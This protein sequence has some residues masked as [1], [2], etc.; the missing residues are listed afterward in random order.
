[1]KKF[2]V[3]Y[4]VDTN[5]AVTAN[6][7]LDINNIPDEMLECVLECVTIIEQVI[8][9]GGLVLDLTQEIVEEYR[10][11]LSMKGAPG[12]GDKFM[13]W[14]YTNQWNFPI[15]NLVNITKSG[16]TYNE[17]PVHND[18]T[19]FDI[20]D[21]KFVATAFAHPDKPPIIQAT[22]SK[23]WGWKDALEEIGINVIFVDEKIIRDTF[24]RK[25]PNGR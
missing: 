20:S 24:D 19:N 4:L 13:K 8:E 2:P 21:R 25:F 6:K 16:T 7:H 5:V 12:I 15:E 3:C 17:F 9:K 11:N 10:S 14:V 1:M 22:D 18:L 23:W